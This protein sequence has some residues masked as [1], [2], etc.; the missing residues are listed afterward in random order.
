MI[1]IIIFFYYQTDYTLKPQ[2]VKQGC[3]YSGQKILSV[4]AWMR[5]IA[6]VNF[7]RIV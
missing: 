2:I 3:L 4:E 5:E 7:T 6:L 1:I